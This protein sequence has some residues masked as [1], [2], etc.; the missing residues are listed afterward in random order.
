MKLYILEYYDWVDKE[1]KP[2]RDCC[3][4]SKEMAEEEHMSAIRKGA[5][6]KIKI[7]VSEV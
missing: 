3:P 1:W 4:V 6:R 5:T 7:R 2:W